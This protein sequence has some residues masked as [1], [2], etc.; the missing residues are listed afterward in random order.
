MRPQFTVIY[1]QVDEVEPL[2]HS[3]N[4]IQYD[5]FFSLHVLLLA[6]EKTLLLRRLNRPE[7]EATEKGVNN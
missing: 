4:L 7:D 3:Q 5:S 1:S 2:F 6:N